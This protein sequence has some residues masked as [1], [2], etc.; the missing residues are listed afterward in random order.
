MAIFEAVRSLIIFALSFLTALLVTPF[1]AHILKKL[2]LRKKN[3]RSAGETPV[4]HKYHKDKASTV[5]MAGIIVW[6]TV[7]GFAFMFFILGNFFDGFASYLNFV[8]RAETYLPLAALLIAAILG[9]VD[10]VT[11]VR[12]HSRGQN[13]FSIVQ[14][15]TLYS[16]IS[17]AG[18]AWF[19]FRL[20]WEVLYIPFV[21]SVTVGPWYMLI[22]FFI[23]MA[24]AFSANETD[25]LDGLAGGVFFFS[26]AALA[27]VSFSLGRYE[28]AAMNASILGALLAFLWFNIHP[29]RFF[30][31]DTGSMSLGI[32]L[33]T[34]AMLTNT[35][36]FLPFFSLVFVFESLSVITQVVSKKFFR[37]KIFRSAPVHHHF[38]AQGW[39]ESQ[40]TMRFW[41]ISAVSVAFGLIFYFLSRFA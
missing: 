14:K 41:I 37:K 39:P 27:V 18:A 16:L 33:G 8:D 10:D 17:A 35:V 23:L 15:L 12:G 31:G 24:T 30:M 7:L 22:F 26:F 1:V 9:L 34:M 32:T 6:G 13:G 11:G 5:T 4:F 2:D 21:G 3:I 19:Y 38:Q 29:A 20:G 28:L 40:I 25:G 36:F